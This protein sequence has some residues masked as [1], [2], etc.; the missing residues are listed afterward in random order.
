MPPAVFAA[1]ERGRV[2]A[3][4]LVESSSAKATSSNGQRSGDCPAQLWRAHLRDVLGNRRLRLF[5]HFLEM[6]GCSIQPSSMGLKDS[7]VED[8]LTRSIREESRLH[9][10]ENQPDLRV[11]LFAGLLVV[12]NQHC[13]SSSSRARDACFTSFHYAKQIPRVKHQELKGPVRR[14]LYHHF[15][16]A[17]GYPRNLSAPRAE[18]GLVL[19]TRVR[20]I[21]N[22]RREDTTGRARRC[23]SC[24]GP[25]PPTTYNRVYCSVRCR[26]LAEHAKARAASLAAWADFWDALENPLGH[27]RTTAR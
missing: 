13:C 21:S 10:A 3:A 7:G 19:N 22:R 25:V 6:G 23:P 1:V 9:H 17:A 12:R 5:L 4:G 15:W 26:R 2:T 27:G 18:T 16:L 24:S 14:I 20:E 11:E 8:E